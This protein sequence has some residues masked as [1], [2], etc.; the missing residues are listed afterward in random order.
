[1][2][3]PSLKAAGLNVFPQG[4][5]AP[6]KG[7]LV[8]GCHKFIRGFFLGGVLFQISIVEEGLASAFCEGGSSHWAEADPQSLKA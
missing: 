7:R 5:A 8:H 6:F 4:E 3:T 1:M 2:P